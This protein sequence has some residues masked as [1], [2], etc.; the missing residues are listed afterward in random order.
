MDHHRKKILQ[1]SSTSS[2]PSVPSARLRSGPVETQTQT[3]AREN[4]P[5]ATTPHGRSAMHALHAVDWPCLAA[6][7]VDTSVSRVLPH[8][9]A[10]LKQRPK[11]TIETLQLH[12]TFAHFRSLASLICPFGPARCLFL[13]LSAS[14]AAGLPV[15]TPLSAHPGPWALVHAPSSL[16]LCLVQNSCSVC[17]RTLPPNLRIDIID[18]LVGTVSLIA[19]GRCRIHLPLQ[20]GFCLS[21]SHPFSR[22][23]PPVWYPCSILQTNNPRLACASSC[24][25]ISIVV[26]SLACS[27]PK[28]HGLTG[29]RPARPLV[30][31][32]LLLAY[33]SNPHSRLFYVRALKLDPWSPTKRN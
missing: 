11:P 31:P 26:V 24:V 25:G 21:A 14:R 32:N 23:G 17:S 19:P 33:P 15:Q 10:S 1:Q 22:T 2:T 18:M 4:A 29:C 28:P 12:H 16:C 3:L 8:A 30:P 7:S 27:S 13:Y 20:M 6:Q 9:S 5:G